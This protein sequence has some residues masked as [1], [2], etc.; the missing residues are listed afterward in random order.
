MSYHLYIQPD[1]P[2]HALEGQI[3]QQCYSWAL[4]EASG[5]FQARGQG[6][7]RDTIEQTLSQND[8]EGVKVVGLIPGD[9]ALFCFA[10]IPAKQARYVRQALP[11]AVEEQLAQDIDSVHLAL[12]EHS[13]RGFRVAA[14]DRNRMAIWFEVFESWSGANLEAIYP[15]AALLPLGDSAWS[16]CLQDD[17]AL[18]SGAGGEWFRMSSVNL[19][20]FAQTLA[21]PA[22]DEVSAE[23]AVTLYGSEADLVASDALIGILEREDRLNLTRQPLELSALELLAHTH[24][25]HQCAPIN[26]CQG[27]FEAANDASGVWRIWRPALI[28]A[29]LWLALQVSVEIGMGY[30]HHHE[31][32]ELEAQAMGIYHQAFPNDTRTTPN[33]LKR[34]LEGKLRVAQQQGPNADFL[35]LLSQAGSE[36]QKLGG[37][38]N[39]KFESVNYSR[40]RGELVVDLKADSYDRLSALRSAI[41]DRGLDAKIG[42]VVNESSGA[43]A[44]LTVSGG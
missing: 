9:E 22:Q 1:A 33:N 38:Q 31:A 37:G 15:E 24:S 5:I 16:V 19:A 8:L 39:I 11:F 12:G 18:V 40:Q 2:F 3:D 34:S 10:E 25:H 36:Y 42:S 17:I 26:L 44:R 13:E 20:I 32:S 27:T 21:A 28:I 43:R 41:G 30:Y 23:I 14:I 7:T 29:G 4:V 6:D 35:A